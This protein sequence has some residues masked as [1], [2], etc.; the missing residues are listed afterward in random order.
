MQITPVF[1]FRIYLLEKFNH[2]QTSSRN[3]FFIPSPFC[4]ANLVHNYSFLLIVDYWIEAAS[5]WSGMVDPASLIFNVIENTIVI[6]VPEYGVA[7][8]KLNKEVLAV[9][10]PFYSF[11][12]FSRKRHFGFSTA[13][14]AAQ[15]THKRIIFCLYFSVCQKFSLDWL[16]GE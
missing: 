5:Q 9:A 8:F 7:I 4:A 12:V 6:Q 3:L 2:F 13:N 15:T 16:K 14:P 10:L 11:H 1:S